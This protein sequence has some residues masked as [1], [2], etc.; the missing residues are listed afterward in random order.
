MYS[1]DVAHTWSTPVRVPTSLHLG[2]VTA[3]PLELVDGR[4]LFPTYD[5]LSATDRTFAVR[6]AVSNDQGATWDADMEISV[7]M[8]VEAGVGLVEPT[9][10]AL[11]DD[12]ILMVIRSHNHPANLAYASW[13][14]DRG[15]TWSVPTT[16][17]FAG[18]APDIVNLDPDLDTGRRLITWGEHSVDN[19]AT[20][21][22]RGRIVNGYDR[23]L[24]GAT[25]TLHTNLNTVDMSYPSGVLLDSSTAFVIHYD[26]H[27]G[28][29]GGN[30]VAIPNS[31]EKL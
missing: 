6:L 21:P 8:P 22:V 17:D 1:D 5:Y 27:R 4:L 14:E 19:L 12:T 15:A 26:A 7:P 11:D 24:R 31:E 16:L 25:F 9:L 3:P 10:S 29:I 2:A 30:A 28:E 23:K 20:R 13:S 18:H